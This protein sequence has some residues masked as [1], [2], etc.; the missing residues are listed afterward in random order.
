MDEQETKRV[1]I[2]VKPSFTFEFLDSERIEAES[3]I[4][5]IDVRKC[6]SAQEFGDLH[7]I[8]EDLEFAQQ[9]FITAAQL[10]F[11]DEPNLLIKSLVFSGVVA[12]ARPFMTGVR[13]KLMPDEFAGV[14]S[15]GGAELH[16]FLVEMRNRHVSH[17]VNAFERCD[18]LGIIVTDSAFQ[19]QGDVTG[20]GVATLTTIGL[21]RARL[22]QIH[23][24]IP[25]MLELL[26]ARIQIV[27]LRLHAEMKDQLASEGKW[28]MMPIVRFPELENIAKKR[29]R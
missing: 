17:S 7:L 25:P 4:V 27:K 14:W 18:A 21:G 24:H 29:A 11:P 10:G 5:P 1:G 2:L 16:T 22:E 8:V 20:V 19:R 26:Q 23:S 28:D 3:Q 15:P 9:C 6:A 12:Y 13:M